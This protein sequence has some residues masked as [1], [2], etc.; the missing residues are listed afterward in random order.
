MSELTPEVR[1]YADYDYD[2]E[3]W[4]VWDCDYE[5]AVSS[6]A[7][8]QQAVDAAKDRNEW[9]EIHNQGAILP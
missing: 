6:W 2:T 4:I 5:K 7:T 9:C 8:E 3:M 1:F